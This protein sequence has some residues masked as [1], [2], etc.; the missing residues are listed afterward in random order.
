M[1]YLALS[2]GV[3]D[4]NTLVDYCDPTLETVRKHIKNFETGGTHHRKE[5]SGTNQKLSNGQVEEFLSY[6]DR[7]SE[8]SSRQYAAW[9]TQ[10]FEFGRNC[11]IRLL[12]LNGF[13]HWKMRRQPN[14]TAAHR[15]KRETWC[16]QN[17]HCN[18]SKVFFTDETYFILH[19]AKNC[20]WS[21]TN[22]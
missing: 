20:Y 9:C 5:G 10:R 2:K 6:A 14:L 13:R 17:Y 15:Y 11:V 8:L 3:S 7:R 4:E 16:L 1:L 19:R 22:Q 18:W 21:L 12:K